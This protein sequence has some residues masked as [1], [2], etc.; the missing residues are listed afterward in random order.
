MSGQRVT[1]HFEPI[2]FFWLERRPQPD[3]LCISKQQEPESIIAV[4][5]ATGMSKPN[6]KNQ[7]EKS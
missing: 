7:T 5:P 1:P 2:K 3:G 6:R 4:S